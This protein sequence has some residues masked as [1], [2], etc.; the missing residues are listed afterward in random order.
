MRVLLV[1]PPRRDR[2]DPSL[3]VPPLGLAHV[4]GALRSAGHEV[5]LLDARAEG[6]GWARLGA[7]IAA[8]R[9]ELVGV[10]AA[11][12]VADLA[13]R[14]CAIAR[15]HARWVMLGGPHPS[16]VGEAVFVQDPGLD[17]AVEGEAEESAPEALAWLT[18]GASGDPP[19]GV[20]VPGRTFRRRVPPADLDALPPPARDL[21]PRRGYRHLLV[22][23]RPWATVVS[24]RGCPHGCT[25]C[26]RAV[27]GTTWRAR[28]AASLLA[29]IDGL[30]VGGVRHVHFYD[31]GFT[32]DRARVLA[33]ARGLEARGRPLGWNCEARVDAV[34]QELLAAMARAGCRL[35]AF[36]VE[37]ASAATLRRLGKGFT[38][39]QVERAFAQARAAGLRTLAYAILGSPGEG[40]AEVA[41]TLRFVRHL[42]AD[43]A[44]FST[45]AA[46]PGAPIAA[47]AGPRVEV[48]GPLDAD[49]HRA[50]LSDLPPEDLER[51]LR[52]AWGGFYLRPGP[53]LRLAG[54]GLRSGAW[55]EAPR[56]ALAAAAWLA[57]S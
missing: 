45:L 30:R 10:T 50:V 41:E 23:A 29:E 53:L 6:V 39:A 43:Y 48:R 7:R 49:E 34:D 22:G 19:A 57:C 27:G 16:A 11:S 2:R 38:P 14:A 56:V 12:P 31:D 47:D 21:L 20:R 32:H 15:P 13:A 4:A 1:Q 35:V 26:D 3:A 33:L 24:S 40:P 37:S 46:Y 52:R 18:A 51:W 28:S 54:A 8:A 5:E 9:A 44:Q 36:G 42:R 25:F 17:L 55:R